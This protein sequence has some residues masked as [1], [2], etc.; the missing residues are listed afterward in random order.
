[1][2]NTSSTHPPKIW[3]LR[4]GQTTWNAERRVQGQLESDL[5]DL[6]RH[7]ASQQAE[8]MAAILPDHRPSAWVSPLRRAQQTAKIALGD[9]NTSTEPRL[10][11]AHAGL[12]QGKTWPEISA[13][14]PEISAANPLA[15]DLFCAAP[16]GEG[17][18]AFHARVVDF[19]A[20]LVS[21]AVLVGHG[22]WG[23]VLRGIICGLD[24]AD[25]AALPNEQGCVYF[26]ENGSET[27]LRAGTPRSPSIV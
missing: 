6:G 4:H 13:Q 20:T 23:Q 7:Q 19:L 3:F 27:V 12:F 22:L 10:A 25:M 16:E 17:F 2:P 24:R 9:Y 14:Y 26:L 15:L 11:E 5:T 21:P 1:M 8:I 18:D